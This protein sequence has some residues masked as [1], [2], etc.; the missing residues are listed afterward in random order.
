MTKLVRFRVVTLSL[1]QVSGFKFC[2]CGNH[3]PAPL[4]ASVFSKPSASITEASADW[5]VVVICSV[6]CP[7]YYFC[8]FAGDIS[9]CSLQTTDLVIDVLL[10]FLFYVVELLHMLCVISI[11][12]LRDALVTTNDFLW[13][14]FDG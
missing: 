8:I 2:F 3:S 4:Y 11:I 14:S 1:L 12:C 13:D 9:P 6:F 7:A 10:V 5:L